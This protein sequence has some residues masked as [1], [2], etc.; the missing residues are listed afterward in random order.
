MGAFT[1]GVEFTIL[2]RE[3]RCKWGSDHKDVLQKLQAII[4]QNLSKIKAIPGFTS[5]QRI[6]CGG[7]YDFKIIMAFK[8]GSFD[9]SETSALGKLEKSMLESMKALEHID[10][11]ETQTYTLTDMTNTVVEDEDEDDDDEDDNNLAL[12]AGD[13]LEDDD[14]DDYEPNEAKLAEDE[15]L[16]AELDEQEEQEKKRAKTS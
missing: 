10:K 11:V 14:D 2:A 12:L 9:D 7:C 15:R 4:T 8:E 3:I 6:I 13:D 16:D 1:E 5:I